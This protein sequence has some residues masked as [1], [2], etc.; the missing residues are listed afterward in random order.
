MS[1]QNYSQQTNTNPIATSNIP[2]GK[3]IDQLRKKVL[4]KIEDMS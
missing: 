4:D 3:E 1:N 2:D